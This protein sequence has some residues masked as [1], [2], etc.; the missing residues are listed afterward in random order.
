MKL[1]PESTRTHRVRRALRGQSLAEFAASLSLL[2]ILVSGLLDLGRLYFAWVGIEDAAGETALYL[3]F[4]PRCRTA[5]SGTGCA[6][7]NNAVY[8]TTNGTSALINLKDTARTTI[9]IIYV[10]AS[11]PNSTTDIY[12]NYDLQDIIVVQITY[13]FPMLSPVMPRIA[14]GP[15]LPLTSFATQYITEK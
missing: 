1:L 2:L 15:N 5:A 4:N 11:T 6:D 10:A 3:S 13:L 8:R 7:P 12:P 14:G 9:N